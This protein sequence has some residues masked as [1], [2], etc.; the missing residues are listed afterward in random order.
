MN[1]GPRIV[2]SETIGGGQG[3]KK[4]ESF[5]PGAVDLDACPVKY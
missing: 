3:V 1:P 5:D 4:L 2:S